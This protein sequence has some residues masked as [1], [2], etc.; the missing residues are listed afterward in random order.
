MFY[1]DKI[2][3]ICGFLSVS[4]LIKSSSSDGLR[5]NVSPEDVLDFSTTLTTSVVTER[6]HHYFVNAAS[7]LGKVALSE[8]NKP[9]HNKATQ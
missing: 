9:F 7:L 4:K 8:Q 3:E 1:S 5:T 6:K 2:K